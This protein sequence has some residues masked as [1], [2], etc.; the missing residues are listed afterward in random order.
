MKLTKE[1]IMNDVDHDKVTL[2][3][4]L[5]VINASAI[6]EIIVKDEPMLLSFELRTF[7]ARI[8][9]NL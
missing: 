7:L 4:G 3:F 9:H 5:F 6:D 1:E 2:A 8:N